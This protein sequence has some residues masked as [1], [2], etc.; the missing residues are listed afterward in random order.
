MRLPRATAPNPELYEFDVLISQAVGLPATGSSI[1]QKPT[2]GSELSVVVLAEALAAHGLRV[3]VAGPFFAFCIDRKVAYVPFCELVGRSDPSGGPSRP[4]ARI[5][6]RVLVSERFGKLPPNVEFERV[7]FDLHDI[8][9]ARLAEVAQTMREIPDSKC[10]V[11]SPFTASLLDGWPNVSVIPCMLPD[12]FYSQPYATTPIDNIVMKGN[13]RITTRNKRYVYGSAAMK[14]LAPTLELWRELKREKS[15]HWKR[16]E[17]VVCSPGYDAIDPKLL[18][19]CKDV[20][21]QHGLSPMGMQA[22]LSASDGVFMV[23]TFPETFGIVFH[24]AEIAG[25]PAYVLRAH[26][27]RDALDTTLANPFTVV[28]RQGGD[29]IDAFV[30]NIEDEARGLMR[31]AH[32]F[33]VSTVL[34]LWLDV[35]GFAARTPEVN[36][37]PSLPSGVPAA[38]ST[39][40]NAA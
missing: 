29:E 3:G 12:E 31:P 32:D 38:G 9:D 20:T 26:G 33:R 2:G 28:D 10:V 40:E 15:Y 4:S 22:L 27:N 8:P 5:R 17:L 30:E 23:S 7:V 13:G 36:V 25:K 35:L 19:G 16:A 18:E 37:P 24:Q 21:I 39:K 34:P 14:G 6:T 11:H 1:R